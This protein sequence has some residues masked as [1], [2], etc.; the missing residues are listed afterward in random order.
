MCKR[1]VK[2]AFAVSLSL[3]LMEGVSRLLLTSSTLKEPIFS[4]DSYAQKVAWANNPKIV[5]TNHTFVDFDAIKGWENKNEY[6]DSLYYG[7]YRLTIKNHRRKSSLN[8]DSRK[9]RI[10]VFGDSF[11]FGEEVD[12][13]QTLPN[14]LQ[15]EV[16]EA[17][18]LNYGVPGYGLDQIYLKVQQLVKQDD[19]NVVV[20]AI[21]SEDLN[22]ME[23]N[24]SFFQKPQFVSH[25]AGKWAI[26]YPE[27][28]PSEIREKYYYHSKFVMLLALAINKFYP[29]EM[30]KHTNVEDLTPWLLD[31]SQ[32]VCQSND[33]VCY[34]T[35]LP[36]P[37]E[38]RN[39]EE[40][41]RY[42]SIN[43]WLKQRCETTGISY[44][45][46]QSLFSNPTN[47]QIRTEQ[48]HW[49]GDGNA[50]IGRYIGQVLLRDLQIQKN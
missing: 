17:S 6:F 31:R 23:S 12:D 2:L 22:R 4:G 8:C 39:R 32:E 45:D 42:L 36:T 16:N 14:F 46:L 30:E 20:L 35:L 10:G 18:V 11:V 29:L 21:I 1:T 27:L 41:L 25:P 50:L 38:V 13:D 26:V 19:L 47:Q 48:M 44:I 43:K 15:E 9:V 40:Y 5:M 3:L 28:Q 24:Y 34:L 37:R 33:C 49:L 7:R